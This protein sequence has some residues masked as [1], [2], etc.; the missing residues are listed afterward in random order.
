MSGRKSE[1]RRTLPRLAA[2]REELL[3]RVY[4]NNEQIRYMRAPGWQGE[5]REQAIGNLMMENA[6]YQEEIEEIVFVT[7]LIADDGK[8]EWSNRAYMLL[9][10]VALL[11]SFLVLY[12][13]MRS[14]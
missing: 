6:L 12:G 11:V 10:I 9:L 14:L 5:D 7:S 4:G 8:T 3:F 2:R 1:D 13:V